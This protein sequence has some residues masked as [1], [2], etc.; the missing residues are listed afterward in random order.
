MLINEKYITF[1]IVPFCSSLLLG[2]YCLVSANT[3]WPTL[4][5]LVF[6]IKSPSKLFNSVLL[7]FC[8]KTGISSLTKR[9]HQAISLGSSKGYVGTSGIIPGRVHGRIHVSGVFGTGRV[10]ETSGYAHYLPVVAPTS[11][12]H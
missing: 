7:S 6:N 8:C 11:D 3:T 5:C 9:N 2:I 4:L 10:A 12:S 1:V